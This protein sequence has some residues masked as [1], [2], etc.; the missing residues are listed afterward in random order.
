MV[1]PQQPVTCRA[2]SLTAASLTVYPALHA[3]LLGLCISQ[4][5]LLLHDKVWW[6]PMPT[7]PDCHA[8]QASTSDVTAVLSSAVRVQW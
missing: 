3:L 6:Q 1:P 4:Q 5:A 7:S 2:S 8:E